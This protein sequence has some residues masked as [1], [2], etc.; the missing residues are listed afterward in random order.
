MRLGDI[1]QIAS[2]IV[3]SYIEQGWRLRFT[4]NCSAFA[5]VRDGE[6][7]AVGFRSIDDGRWPESRALFVS[8]NEKGDNAWIDDLLAPENVISIRMFYKVGKDWFVEDEAAAREADERRISR[9]ISRRHSKYREERRWFNPTKAFL[10]KWVREKYGW[11][12]VKPSDVRVE[13]C[14]G[15]SYDKQLKWYR[16]YKVGGNE[17]SFNVWFPDL[18]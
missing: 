10:D 9:R 16:V 15:W 6:E 14:D 17:D 18:D 11:K 4:M 1:Q 8:R 2:D 13:R 12:T 5:L 7:I 3:S